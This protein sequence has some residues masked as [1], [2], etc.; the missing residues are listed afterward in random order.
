MSDY[1]KKFKS[2][3]IVEEEGQPSSPSEPRP[4]AVPPARSAATATVE[5]ARVLNERFLEVLFSALD[6]HN[7][8]GF[9]YIEY[10]KSLK[11]LSGMDMSVATRFRS[12]FATAQTLGVT[13][14]KLLDSGRYYLGVLQQEFDNFGQAHAQQRQRLVDERLREQA[15]VEAGIQ[16]REAQIK[17]LQA[18]I[19]A[20]QERL[21]VIGE[22]VRSST[23]RI[24][25]TRQEFEA[26][27]LHITEQIKAD[28]L[29]IQT[30]L[31]D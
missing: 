23:D 8:D 5:G 25:R 15:E 28:L 29:S 19:E 1:W 2:I 16:Q 30:H 9:D 11:N 18:E 13:K 17:A 31:T 21:R 22:D 7:K 10:S 24:E 3:F 20:G 4:A 14:E 27:F 12:A 26:A 6:Q